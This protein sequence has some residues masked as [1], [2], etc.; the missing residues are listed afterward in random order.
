MRDLDD[1]EGLN[2]ARQVGL[3][4]L[5]AQVPQVRRDES[6]VDQLCEVVGGR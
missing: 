4:Q 3:E 1:G 6:V 2:H 5:L